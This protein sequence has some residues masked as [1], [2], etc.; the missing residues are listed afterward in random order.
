MIINNNNRPILYLFYLDMLTRTNNLN[1]VY[2]QEA[3]RISC[4]YLAPVRIL[5]YE[6]QQVTFIRVRSLGLTKAQYFRGGM[7]MIP[8]PRS[9]SASFPSLAVAF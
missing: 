6:Q 8:K 2:T 5:V 1:Y 7:I 3:T 9:R 4:G